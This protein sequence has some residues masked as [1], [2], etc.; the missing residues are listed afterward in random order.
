MTVSA[1]EAGANLDWF[2]D[3][4][5]A[6]EEI[7]IVRGDRRLVRMEPLESAHTQEPVR[8]ERQLGTAKGLVF[9]GPDFHESLPDDVIAEFEK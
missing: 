4:A 3:K 6:G 1:A 2:L 7:I 5:V 9:A 8:R